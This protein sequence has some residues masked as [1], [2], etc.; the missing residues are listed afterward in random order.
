MSLSLMAYF[1]DEWRHLLVATSL[2]GFLAIAL[3]WWIPESP[4]WLISMGRI[5][6]ADYVVRKIAK[7][8]GRPLPESWTL[9]KALKAENAEKAIANE[10]EAKATMFDLLKTRQM[11]WKTLIL[12]FNWFINSLCYYGLTL[13]APGYGLST[14]MNFTINGLLEVPAY[15]FALFI[16]AY[17]G[18][19]FPYFTSM[20]LTGTLKKIGF[21]I[22]VAFFF[23]VETVTCRLDAPLDYRRARA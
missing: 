1:I 21:D 15:A 3:I 17:K 16:L 10:G 12:Y 22:L 18:R 20:I 11:R 14:L 19:R 7:A 6:E 2:P 23:N 13:N 4:R 8:N 9:K 5:A